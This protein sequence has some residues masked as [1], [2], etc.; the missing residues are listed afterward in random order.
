M[1]T[2]QPQGKVE[3]VKTIYNDH[4]KTDI[5]GRPLPTPPW[6]TPLMSAAEAGHH[7]VVEAL[8]AR[9][10]DVNAADMENTTALML[11][12]KNGM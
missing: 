4:V 5:L 1:F 6:R 2:S 11:A 12:A 9:G 3:T 7:D 8:L 10:A